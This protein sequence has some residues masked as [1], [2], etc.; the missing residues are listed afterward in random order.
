[1]LE[2]DSLEQY[3]S[4]KILSLEEAA[5]K[6]ETFKPQYKV[7]LCHGGFDLL[8]PGHLKHFESAKNL[9]DILFVSVTTDKFNGLRKGEGRPIFT[10][11]LRAYAISKS[12]DVD[13]VTISDYEK[14]V[15]IIKLL[16]PNYYIKGPDFKTKN[17]PGIIAEREAIEN[18]GGEMIYTNDIPMSTTRI[19]KYIRNLPVNKVLLNVDRDGT[20]IKNNDYLGKKSNWKNEIEF[21]SELISF[22]ENIQKR[23]NTRTIVVTNQSGVARRYFDC[24]RVEDINNFVNSRLNEEGVKVDVWE[25]CPDM[26]LEFVNKNP[27]IEF[28]PKYIK[29]ETKRKPSTGMVHDGLKKLNS[30]LD[31][32]DSVFVLGDKQDDELLAG[33]LGC[34]FINVKSKTFNDLMREFESLKS[35]I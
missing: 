7:G 28:D 27:D 17:T 22:L 12:T 26:D 20:L 21:N 1:M 11:D 33:N 31:D 23:Y 34:H 29:N 18:V 15:E 4:K 10:H 32:F 2:V 24:R 9:C 25:Y 35:R 5:R 6:I 19:I 3:K 14:G 8:H 30:K 16:K 13:Y